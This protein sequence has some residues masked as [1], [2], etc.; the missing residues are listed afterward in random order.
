MD[1]RNGKNINALCTYSLLQ[2]R[3]L[4]P[5]K[6]N[7]TVIF[8]WV[9]FKY[10]ITITWNSKIRIKKIKAHFV[11]PTYLTFCAYYIYDDA[12]PHKFSHIPYSGWPKNKIE[13]SKYLIWPQQYD[14]NR[15]F[16]LRRQNIHNMC[17]WMGLL[18]YVTQLYLQ[19][20]LTLLTL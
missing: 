13:N 2:K 11:F 18:H 3:F 19:L 10:Y 14:N 7:L 20:S 1:Q 8:K 16:F 4:Q 12:M 17:Q 6:K 15:N 9:I 5:G